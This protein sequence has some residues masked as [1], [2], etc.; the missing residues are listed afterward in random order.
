MEG[1]ELY[2]N[3]TL[4]ELSENTRIGITVQANDIGDIQ[5]KRANFTNQFKLPKTNANCNALG[6]PNLLNTSSRTPYTKVRARIIQDGIEIVA[7]GYG[8]VDGITDTIN[9]TVYSGNADFF[10][11]IQNKKLIDLDFSEYN[12]VWNLINFQDNVVNQ[13]N[14]DGYVYGIVNYGKMDLGNVMMNYTPPCV[15]AKKIIQKIVEGAGFSI[16][17]GIYEDADSILNKM[18]VPYSRNEQQQDNTGLDLN[19]FKA[20]AHGTTATNSTGFSVKFYPG[21]GAVL[22]DNETGPTYFD[23]SN[24]HLNGVY[25]SVLKSMQKFS[26]HVDVDVTIDAPPG[27][28]SLSGSNYIVAQVIRKIYPT[29]SQGIFAAGYVSKIFPAGQDGVL[30]NYSF[31][32]ESEIGQINGGDQVFVQILVSSVV[33]FYNGSGNVINTQGTTTATLNTASYWMN[34]MEGNLVYGQT[35]YLNT[36]LP[37]ML[38]SDFIKNILQLTGGQIQTDGANRDVY[39]E[40]FEKISS[41]KSVAKN[42]SDK[43]DITA[44][45]LKFRCSY[46]QANYLKYKNDKSNFDFPT[47]GD[48]QFNLNDETLPLEKTVV[49]LLFAGTETGGPYNLGLVTGY[50]PYIKKVDS[51][52]TFLSLETEPRILLYER[53]TLADLI[54]YLG[55]PLVEMTYTFT[56]A[57]CYTTWFIDT[58]NDR[59]FQLGFNN[60]LIELFYQ[61][62]INMLTDYKEISADVLLNSNDIGNYFNHLIPVFIEKYQEYFYCNSIENFQKGKL[63]KANLIRL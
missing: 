12:H 35:L 29:T 4:I 10:E 21:Y 14:E 54:Y 33:T 34:T 6:F 3:N 30:T 7:D 57:I 17:G 40:F 39:M 63:T 27:T 44:D 45:E 60:N 56:S 46:S 31:D 61:S 43:I 9:V 5:N 48:G 23:N 16:K 25:T 52:D 53:E 20:G 37:D 58:I 51:A 47:I 50:A 59:G 22:F 32:L 15:R 38:Q 1:L 24:L 18:V 11:L 8:I 42:W 55:D 36:L 28:A 26:V 41:N 2:L 62:L 19:L 13:T 49:Q